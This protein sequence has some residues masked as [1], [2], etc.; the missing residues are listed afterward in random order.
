MDR[1]MAAADAGAPTILTPGGLGD[2]VHP[3]PRS[4]HRQAIRQVRTTRSEV[5]NQFRC[6]KWV[7][8][9]LS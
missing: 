6:C 8:Y 9:P 2:R 4:L 3:G 7:V 5:T 1:R